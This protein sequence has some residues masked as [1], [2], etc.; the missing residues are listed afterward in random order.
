MTKRYLVPVALLV[1]LLQ[2][3][4]AQQDMRRVVDL[5]V[6]VRLINSSLEPRGILLRLQADQMPGGQSIISTDTSGKAVFANLPQAIYTVSAEFPGFISQA[7]TVDLQNTNGSYIIF[8]LK[9]KPDAKNV[10]AVPPE[11]PYATVAANTDPEAQKKFREGQKQLQKNNPSSAISNFKRAIEIAPD[12]TEA[13]LALGT[14]YMDTGGFLQ[15]QELLTKVVT[16]EPNLPG[17]RFALGAAYNR[18][19]NYPQAEEQLRAGLKL[20]NDFA[21]GHYELARALLATGKLQEGEEHVRKAL[22]LDKTHARS[23]LLLGNVQLAKKDLQGAISSYR[24][25]LKLDPKGPMAD[26][27]KQMIEKLEKES[28]KGR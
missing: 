3:M 26:A 23:Y 8:E 6:R 16:K 17:A 2:A 15:A 28:K 11:G 1:A 10:A 7:Q 4:T 12:Y 14:T 13:Y 18:T 9:P 27:T 20:K 24:E 25:Y 19:K 21:D 5:R 22:E